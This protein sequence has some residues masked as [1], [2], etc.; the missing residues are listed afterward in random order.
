MAETRF[1][2]PECGER[3]NG[4]GEAWHQP[5]C[6]H[7]S[8]VTTRR[9]LGIREP[10][11]CSCPTRRSNK[12]SLTCPLS[13]GRPKAQ[14]CSLCGAERVDGRIEHKPTCSFTKQR[15]T[16]SR[17]ERRVSQWRGPGGRARAPRLAA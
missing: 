9:L 11:P 5:G 15:E 13:M 8:P 14:T 4:D 10:D 2:C 17:R 3:A 1:R 7:E 6:S 12:H 16:K